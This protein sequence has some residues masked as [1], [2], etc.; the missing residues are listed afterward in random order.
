MYRRLADDAD[1]AYYWVR[2]VRQGVLLSELGA[3]SVLAYVLTTDSPGRHSVLLLVLASAVMVGTP[4]LLLLPLARMMHDRRGPLLFYGW[5]GAVTALVS[6]AARVD[7][8]SASPSRS[9]CS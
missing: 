3:G 1:R 8:G 4:A 6:I 9:C 2:H 7:G 5:S